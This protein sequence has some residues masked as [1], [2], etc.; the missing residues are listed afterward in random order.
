MIQTRT[1]VLRNEAQHPGE[2]N[3]KL[4]HR[5]FGGLKP[6]MLIPVRNGNAE[7]EWNRSCCS[8]SGVWEAITLWACRCQYSPQVG[9]ECTLQQQNR[10]LPSKEVIVWLPM[11]HFS[12]LHWQEERKR[13][14]LPCR[15]KSLCIFLY[16]RKPGH[17]CTRMFPMGLQVYFTCKSIFLSIYLFNILQWT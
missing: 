7:L 16:S 4:I 11:N 6:K 2:G 10:S 3:S 15:A 5:R 14:V 17:L 13:Q 1:R 12:H 8:F 9:Q